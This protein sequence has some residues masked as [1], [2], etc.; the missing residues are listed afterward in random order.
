MSDVNAMKPC[1]VVLLIGVLLLAP[2][3]GLTIP[4]RSGVDSSHLSISQGS[5][6]NFFK[7]TILPKSKSSSY[8]P[9]P[10]IEVTNDTALAAVAINGTGI[11]SNPYILEGW[12]ITTNGTHGI[13]ICNTTAH[14]VIRNCWVQTGKVMYISGIYIENA[15]ENT[16]IISH[17]FCWNNYIDIG[18]RNADFV[19][20]FNN[21]CYL[22]W[23]GIRIYRSANLMVM[24]NFC[25]QNTPLSLSFGEPISSRTQ[26]ST[27]SGILFVL[28][29]SSMITNNL[30]TQNIDAGIRLFGSHNITAANN[31][32]HLN[33]GPGID[34]LDSSTI[35]IQNNICHQ[36]QIGISIW[37]DDWGAA[38]P[39][40]A[41]QITDNLFIE[42]IRHGISLSSGANNHLHHNTFLGNN[43]GSIQA[44]DNGINNTWS[45]S[46]TKQGNYWLD[47]NDTERYPLAG[48][49]NATDLYPLPDILDFD[50][51]GM[52]NGWEYQVGLNVTLNDA[53]TDY[54]GD[55]MPNLWEY[56]MELNVTDPLDATLDPDGDG[57]TNF[58]EYRTGTDPYD[59]DTDDDFFPDGLDQG[60]WGNP[61]KKWDNPLTRLLLVG[62][63]S[64]PVLGPWVGVIAFKLPELHRQRKR[65]LQQLE[66][67]AERF[68]ADA[69]A[70]H[71][72]DNLKE[73][74]KA[75]EEIKQ[76]FLDCTQ[77]LQTMRRYVSRKW[78]PFFLR[79]DLTPFE[80][81][82]TSLTETYEEFQLIRLQ[83]VKEF[84]VHEGSFLDATEE[85]SN[86]RY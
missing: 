2:L 14:F 69:R 86:N 30:C 53:A 35:I 81:I 1:P 57:L 67:Q 55:Q 68:Y 23:F 65:Q 31:S 25:T 72:L 76:L 16:A 71:S 75:T 17:N 32:C 48:S 24:N 11:S 82:V 49:A 5:T 18:V 79:P 59:A 4:L 42:N 27:L 22:N 20:I 39:P 83:K 6:K 78:L 12:N 66:Q 34:I 56:L 44:Q 54:D 29:A 28:S 62:S 85:N 41:C 40:E 21:T 50:E 19:T 70:F 46:S 45:D 60:W 9:H 43:N 51:D 80:T 15:T 73:L 13:Y 52:P 58:Q 26:F 61:R 47:Y 8:T 74:E 38:S 33:G 77:I 3:F 37:H 63:L 64:L 84:M 7:E 36:N 10:P